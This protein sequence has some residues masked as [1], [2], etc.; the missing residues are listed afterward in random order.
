LAYST[1]AAL[2]ASLLLYQIQQLLQIHD[3]VHDLLMIIAADDSVY[4]GSYIFLLLCL[5]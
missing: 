5:G 2:L 4:F 3:G 1:K